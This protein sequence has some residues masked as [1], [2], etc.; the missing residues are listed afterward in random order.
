[1]TRAHTL[2]HATQ[3]DIELLDTARLLFRANWKPGAP[4]RLLGVH[5][6]SFERTSGQMSLLET[7][8]SDRWQKALQAADLLRDK[9]GESAVSL[10]SAVKGAYRERTHENPASR[11]GKHPRPE[12]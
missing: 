11:P 12:R 1:I 6:A 2:D 9:Y 7:D 3:L 5:A 8:R 4:V 10:G